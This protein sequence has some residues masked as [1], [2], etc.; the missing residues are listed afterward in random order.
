MALRIA[1]YTAKTYSPCA[2]DV[3]PDPDGGAIFAC[4]I[5][6]M[7]PWSFFRFSSFGSSACNLTRA[8]KH[9]LARA[10]YTVC[11][12]HFLLAAAFNALVVRLSAHAGA[13]FALIAAT[14]L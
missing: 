7:H 8:L 6:A 13:E 12:T 4:I 3:M 10:S 14:T 1:I 5:V 11:L 2:S 9:V